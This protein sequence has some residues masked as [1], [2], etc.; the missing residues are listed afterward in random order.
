MD[1]ASLPLIKNIQNQFNNVGLIQ[2]KTITFSVYF[3]LSLKDIIEILIPFVDSNPLY[4]ERANHYQI[5]K[6]VSI[7][8]SKEKTL[9]T[10]LKI[11]ELAYN[12]NKDGKRRRMDKSDYIKLLYK[13]YKS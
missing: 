5:F 7:L 4:S 13:K 9:E 3:I 1:N 12:A 11:V 8:L 10:K 2:Y 6:E